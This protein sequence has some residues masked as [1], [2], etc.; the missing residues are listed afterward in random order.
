MQ[1]GFVNYINSFPIFKGL[2]LVGLKA[3][4]ANP[5]AISDLLVKQKL[6]LGQISIFRYLKNKRQFD[7]LDDFCVA[8]KKDQIDSVLFFSEYQNLAE[9]KNKTKILITSHSTA[10]FNLLKI[11]LEK[12]YKVKSDYFYAQI[13]QDNLESLKNFLVIGDLSLKIENKIKKLYKF[14]LAKIWYQKTKLPFV[15]SVFVKNKNYQ[16]KNIEFF[17]Q[18]LLKNLERNLSNLDEFSKR[19]AEEDSLGIPAKRVHDYLRLISYNLRP[20][21]RES[22][23]LFESLLF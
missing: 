7:C 13:E 23:K 6:G 9:I 11:I 20:E 17:I 19:V 12:F 14:D 1:I 3:G 2:S 15:F 22:I 4:F 8:S 18:T 21:D 16:E 5:R 10:S